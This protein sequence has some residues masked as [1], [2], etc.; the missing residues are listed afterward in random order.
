MAAL[1]YFGLAYIMFTWDRDACPCNE[2]VAEAD[3]EGDGRSA[4]C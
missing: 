1:N 2:V 3:A 4:W